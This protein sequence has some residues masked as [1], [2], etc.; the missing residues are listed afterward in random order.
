M[1]L[2]QACQLPTAPVEYLPT[3]QSCLVERFDRVKDGAGN[4]KRLY[5]AD[6]CQLLDKPSGVKYE[7]DGGPSFKDC[8][9]LV[10]NRSAVPLTDCHNM[11]RWLFFNL[12]VGNN[13]SHAKNLSMLYAN[14]KLRLAPF[15]DLMCTKVYSGLSINFSFKIGQH[16]EPGNIHHHDVCELADSVGANRRV[17]LR[18]A[19]DIADQIEKNLP[20]MV[21]ELL[22]L[23]VNGSSEQILLDRVPM[24][25]A[26]NIKKIKV[27]FQ[28]PA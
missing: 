27:R 15:Y 24:T 13:D 20:H 4:L 26:S 5:Q 1:K 28:P 7:N 10:R 25:I 16:F 22:R 14:G 8:Y 2:A 9:D 11:V 12:M 18:L 6:L 19:L 17:I 3:V 21:Q 23:T